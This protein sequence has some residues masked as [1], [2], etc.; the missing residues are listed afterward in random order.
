MTAA[1][2]HQPPSWNTLNI[3]WS[4]PNAKSANCFDFLCVPN[5][6]CSHHS[7]GSDMLSLNHFFLVFLKEKG[8]GICTWTKITIETRWKTGKRNIHRRYTWH[9]ARQSAC[10]SWTCV[11]FATP[12]LPILSSRGCA[13]P[14]SVERIVTNGWCSHNGPNAEE[15]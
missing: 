1:C 6:S 7:A 14:S 9:F 3:T 10:A 11:V 2:R 4:L 8:G 13:S 5:D 12:K 15:W